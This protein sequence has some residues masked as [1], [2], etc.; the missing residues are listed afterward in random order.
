MVRHSNKNNSGTLGGYF[1]D[2]SIMTMVMFIKWLSENS[3]WEQFLKSYQLFSRIKSCLKIKYEK[4]FS[5]LVFLW[6]YYRIKYNIKPC[7]EF[8]DKNTL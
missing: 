4:Q 1:K 6:S 7:K 3:I 5:L 8:F 2:K